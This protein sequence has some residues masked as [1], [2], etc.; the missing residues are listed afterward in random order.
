MS[1]TKKDVRLPFLKSELHHFADAALLNDKPAIERCVEFL[2]DETKWVGD[3][4][5][6]ALMARRLKHCSLTTSQEDRLLQTILN[7]LQAGRFSEGFKD[8]LRLAK[9]L[10]PALTLVAADKC[11]NNNPYKD[12]VARYARWLLEQRAR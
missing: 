12:H 7:R 4:R 11:L 6:R 9:I 2:V 3:G 10:N 1:A 5:V 8:Q